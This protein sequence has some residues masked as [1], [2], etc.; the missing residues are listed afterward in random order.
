MLVD[1]L[2]EYYPRLYHMAEDGSWP[3]IRRYGLLSTA[4]LVDLFEVP[5]PQRT[6]LLTQHRPD[7]VSLT[8]PDHGHAVIRDQ[9]PLQ[10]TKLEQLLTDMTVTEWIRLLNEQVF[11][12]VHPERLLT[13]LNARAYQSRPHLVLTVST[14]SLVKAHEE[15]IRLARINSG[16]TAYLR[17]HRGLTTFQRIS[18]YRHPRSRSRPAKHVVELA[19]QQHVPDIADHIL[20]VHRQQADREPEIIYER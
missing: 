13:L 6:E 14:Q 15:R 19:V 9:K 10:T 17:G 5:E 8:H 11:F 12:W 2:I 7:L 4:A 3:S 1:E 16:A 18:D 20:Q